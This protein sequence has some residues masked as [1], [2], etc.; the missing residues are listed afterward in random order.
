MDAGA[1]ELYARKLGWLGSSPDKDYKPP[2]N[3]TRNE[4]L[5][6]S[7]TYAK[8]RELPELNGKDYLIG[9]LTEIGM[10]KSSGMGLAPI[11]WIDIKAWAELTQT[12]IT[13][14]ETLTL[15]NASRGYV[16]EQNAGSDPKRVAPDDDRDYGYSPEVVS[17]GVDANIQA[18]IKEQSKPAPKQKKG[19]P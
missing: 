16:A 3:K 15:I 11:D 7:D 17:A 19:R 6:I 4:I 12:R 14:A 18:I 9:W 2:K 1:V 5:S 13:S 8:A 10:C